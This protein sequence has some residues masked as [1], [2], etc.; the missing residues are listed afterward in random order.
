[1]KASSYQMKI[2]FLS[3][4]SGCKFY[5][6]RLRLAAEARQLGVFDEITMADECSLGEDFWR[7]RGDL[8]RRYK[9]GFGLWSWKPYLIMKRLEAMKDGGLLVYVDVGCSLNPEGLR[10]L[11]EYLEMAARGPGWLG[12]SLRGNSNGAWTKRAMLRS[13]GQD[14]PAIRGRPQLASG[15][16]FIRA[17][18]STRLL[19]RRWY[20]ACGQEADMNDVCSDDE[21]P[22]FI[23]HRHDQ[24]AFSLLAAGGPVEDIPDESW[25]EPDWAANRTYPVHARRWKHRIPWPTSWLRSRRLEGILRRL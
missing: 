2:F 13:L 17:C 18:D 10:R 23:A 20:D 7:S 22:E 15:I 11:E 5:G 8:V 3:F 12:F 9:R 24:S 1:M 4:G 25:F 21:H 6:S 14:D 19:A 16:H